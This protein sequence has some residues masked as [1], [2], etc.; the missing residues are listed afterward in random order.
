MT[1]REKAYLDQLEQLIV[2]PDRTPYIRRCG[3]GR[4]EEKSNA[5][6]PVFD[7][8]PMTADQLNGPRP[9][10]G[11][12]G[13]AGRQFRPVLATEDGHIR[14]GA[15][16]IYEIEIEVPR[17]DLGDEQETPQVQTPK[18]QEP[19]AREGEPVQPSPEPS[20]EERR[21]KT[22]VRH[23]GM[24]PDG[25]LFLWDGDR[26]GIYRDHLEQK[27]YDLIYVVESGGRLQ[28][29]GVCL[30]PYDPQRVGMLS[31]GIL[32]WM[33]GTM[34]W[35]RDALVYHFD[36]PKDVNKVSVLAQ[37]ESAK[38]PNGP[39]EESVET[40]TNGRLVRGRTF[41]IHVGKHQWHGVY[42]GRDS[43]GTVVAHNTNRVWS[44]MHLDLKRFGT[45]V[46]FGDLLPD[47][48][49][50][51]IEATVNGQERDLA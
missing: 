20:R 22:P 24:F 46:E 44:L 30:A 29:K 34:R 47:A 14:L 15:D 27:G 49:I 9:D 42:W 28:P 45:G 32:K 51:E 13:Q 26:L 33:E 2:S 38:Q 23:E 31:N 5:A 10:A 7:S 11:T 35:D 1:V 21:P 40:V 41:T 25:T 19:S 8:G 43:L 37:A 3:P 6:E 17:S 12:S 16:G 4:K 36:N 48:M 50:L 39:S 18:P